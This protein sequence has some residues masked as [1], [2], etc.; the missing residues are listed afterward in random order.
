[1]P[2]IDDF[3]ILPV[4]ELDELLTKSPDTMH[5]KSIMNSITSIDEIG[6][7]PGA[8]EA[9]TISGILSLSESAH[10][11]P[12]S[13][14]TALQD[15][16]LKANGSPLTYHLTQ[17]QQQL[18]ATYGPDGDVIFNAELKPDGFYTFTLNHPIVRTDAPNLAITQEWHNETIAENVYKISQLLETEPNKPYQFT[19][20]YI[21]S[22]GLLNQ[23]QIYWDH[24]LL[25][26]I[27]TS[28]NEARGY[29]FSVEGN[30]GSH[31]LLEIVGTGSH[32]VSEF[33]Q[34]VSVTSMA[35]FKLPIDFAVV[36]ESNEHAAFTVNVTTT[37]AIE[38]D[39]Q[40]H[41]DIFYE[42][43]VYQ[44]IIVNDTNSNDNPLAT[45]NLDTLFKQLAIEQENRLIEVVQR[46]EDGLAT[47]VYEIKIS[48][49]AQPMEPITI[50]DVQLSFPGGNGGM[51]VFSRHIAIDEGSTPLTI[52]EPI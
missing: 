30:P 52:L 27:N 15:L 31:T 24:Q 48:D 14:Q 50:A 13:E 43:S 23:L 36:T 5:I 49:K 51:E 6:L 45:I 21:P 39:N 34:D 11:A 41:F 35:Q 33:I 25:Q 19:L 46:V 32:H 18:T 17:N 37:P 26:T 7:L 20:H 42:Q 1:M 3:L 2:A 8:S 4:S 28:Q 44:T 10:F 38:L 12:L 29:T 9:K 22:M 47:N 40:K 16:D